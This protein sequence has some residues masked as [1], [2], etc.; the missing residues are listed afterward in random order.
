MLGLVRFVLVGKKYDPCPQDVLL[1][2]AQKDAAATSLY[3]K[4]YVKCLVRE[5]ALS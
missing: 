2:R 4:K 3:E 1:M 5:V